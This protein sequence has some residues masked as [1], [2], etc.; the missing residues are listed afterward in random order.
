MEGVE[1]E[2]ALVRPRQILE[3]VKEIEI[4]GRAQARQAPV[5]LPIHQ[6]PIQGADQAL[7]EEAALV[8]DDGHVT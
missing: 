6:G 4:V 8:D 1:K 2:V 5:A 7:V 3:V